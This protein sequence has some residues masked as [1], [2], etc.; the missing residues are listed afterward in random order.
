MYRTTGW[1]FLSLGRSLERAAMM[2]DLLATVADPACPPGGLDLAIEVGDSIM[3]HR[4][5]YA[6]I[7]RRESVIDLLALDEAN[8]RSV[9]FHLEMIAHL[10]QDLSVLRP[11]GQMRAFTAQVAGLQADLAR[12]TVQGLD[13]KALVRLMRAIHGLSTGLHAT[14]MQ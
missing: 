11:A 13:S 7:T 12:Q 9:R 2:S 4:Q 8:P 5:R 10:V 3:V 1:Q 14:F 6:V